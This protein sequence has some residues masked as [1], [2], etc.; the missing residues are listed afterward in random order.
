MK[1]HLEKLEDWLEKYPVLES[2]YYW[3]YR[4]TIARIS[5]AWFD[6]RIFYQKLTRGYSDNE[7]W[8]LYSNV[9]DYTLPRLK[10]LKKEKCGIPYKLT[11]KKWDSILESIIWS[12]NEV[13]T[14]ENSPDIFDCC[15]F[16]EMVEGGFRLVC[17]DKQ[18]H[19]EGIDKLKFYEKKKQKGLTYFGKYFQHL[20]D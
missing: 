14:E 2:T 3:F 7:W 6:I 9:A 10:H 4:N 18:K 5:E 13:A 15:K 1:N 11:E 16:V 17:M 12:L 8:N 19:K 20:W